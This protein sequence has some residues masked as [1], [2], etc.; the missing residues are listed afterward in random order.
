[1]SYRP[2]IIAAAATLVVLDQGFSRN[3][4]ELKLSPLASTLALDIVSLVQF[5]FYLDFSW[6][7]H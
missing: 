5:R 1:M 6:E 4:L 3:A 2:S 7:V